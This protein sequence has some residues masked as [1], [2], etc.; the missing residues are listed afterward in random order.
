M[1]AFEVGMCSFD[2]R[3]AAT[4]A[5]FW[6]G[7]LERPVDAGATAAYATIGLEDEG[8]ASMFVRAEEP[9]EGRNRFM[10][11]LGGEE[12]WRQEAERVEALG[13]TRIAE[14]EVQ[15]HG[16]SSFATR[17]TTRFGSPVRGHGSRPCAR[18]SSPRT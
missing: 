10:L 9:G 2:C 18:S 3:D 7:L 5:G 12:L 13:A 11:D 4:L 6:S 1:I 14:H 17:R 16:G 8:P 15:G